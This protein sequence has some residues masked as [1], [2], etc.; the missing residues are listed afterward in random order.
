MNFL[1]NLK[2]GLKI[3]LV[4]SILVGVIILSITL[5]SFLVQKSRVF[6][7]LN[8]SVESE[9]NDYSDFI[10][11][12]YMKNQQIVKTGLNLFKGEFAS[13]GEINISPNEM[14]PYHAINQETKA[15]ISIEV[16][17]W[18]INGQKIQNSQMLVDGIIR[19]EI[20]AATIFQRIP[21]GFLRIS[22]S[23]LDTQGKRVTGT[24]IPNDSPVAK[25]ILLGNEF[26]GRA[27]VVNDWYLAGYTPIKKEG[28]IV[29]MLFVGQPEKNMN[30]L[31]EHFYSRAFYGTGYSFIVA[32][33]GTFLIHPKEEGKNISKEEYFVKMVSGGLEKGEIN[34]LDNGK[35]KM[36]F[37]RYFKEFDSY[38][39][40]TVFTDDLSSS[41]NK[42]FYTNIL[43]S[44]LAV[45]LFVLINIYLSHTITDG[46]KKGVE[47]ADSLSNGDLG[48]KIDLDQKDEIGALVSS[49]NKM[50]DKLRETVGEITSSAENISSATF[51]MSS[52]SEQ[53]SQNASEQASTVDQISITMKEIT[54]IIETNAQHAKVTQQLSIKAQE[55]VDKAIHEAV[56]AM[57]SSKLISEKIGIISDIAFQTNILALNAAVEAARAGE[58]GRGFAVVADEVRRLADTSKIAA[59]EITLIAKDSLKKSE[60]SSQKL[61][62]L[63]PEIE[64]T[65]DLVKEIAVTSKQQTIGIS[66][67]NESLQ[68]LNDTSQQNAAA[69]EELASSAEELSSQA[70]ILADLVSFFKLKS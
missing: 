34:Y 63:L 6:T 16:P 59:Q 61:T 19:K 53:L 2:I 38:L 1:R 36:M 13:L 45:G 41:V 4:T 46:L 31:K 15:E 55:S 10:H 49:L 47:F 5:Y 20:S 27:F 18:L 67:I 64:K 28:K 50:V 35:R 14:I 37:Y 57:E 39:G 33:D 26:Y 8:G 54:S 7:D 29:G 58:H 60:S 62:L 21:E 69:S 42:L 25:A 30:D 12:E 40:I 51:Q 48:S 24:F 56:D 68:Q 32:K 9:F 70:E 22:T 52:T 44:L 43:I 17:A 66:Q 11:L 3:N 23:I 65:T